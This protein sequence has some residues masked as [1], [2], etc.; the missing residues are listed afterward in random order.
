MRQLADGF[1]EE[2]G[3][4]DIADT[5]ARADL[6]MELIEKRLK[7]DVDYGSIPKSTKKC[8]FKSGAE[9]LCEAYGFA[10]VYE[11]LHRE[12]DFQ[13]GLFHYEVKVTLVQKETGA[14]VAEGA[15][16]CNSFEKV[17]EKKDKYSIGNTVLKIAKKRAFVDAT[18]L[19]T[20]SS[21]VFTQDVESDCESTE[22][23]YQESSQQ[24]TYKKEIPKQRNEAKV[25][26]KQ[27][28]FIYNLL[29]AKRISMQE[30]RKELQTQFGKNDGKE[31]TKQEA[32][33][34]IEWLRDIAA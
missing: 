28:T 9:K 19:A 13:T 15:G 26:D 3:T 21:A 20:S 18:L 14:V 31:L 32:S 10:P 4:M 2:R 27:L 12:T 34:C 29:S 22:A 17:Y 8:L 11:I 23:N 33:Q 6:L 24:D 16:C 7:V 1:V 5:Q 30:F 25:S